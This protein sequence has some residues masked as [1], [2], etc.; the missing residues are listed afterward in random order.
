MIRAEYPNGEDF[1]QFNTEPDENDEYETWM[2]HVN[3]LLSNWSCIFGQGCPGLTSSNESRY[4]DDIGCCKM[5]AWF[6]DTEDYDRTVKMAAQLTDEDWDADKKKEAEKNGWA[7]IYKRDDETGHLNGKT[8][9][10]D[11]GCIFSN[12]STGSVGSTGKVGCAFH[13]LAERTNQQHVDV[14]PQVC[15]QLPLRYEYNEGLAAHVITPWD[16]DGWGDTDEDGSHDSI[17]C[18]WCVD[19]PEAYVGDKAVF[20]SMEG[21]LRRLMTD[22]VYEQMAVMLVERAKQNV[23]PVMPGSVRNDGRPM[24]PL[25]IGNRQPYRQPS[26]TNTPNI[27]ENMRNDH[28][29]SEATTFTEPA[30]TSAG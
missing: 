24:L 14:M 19:S 4:H 9:V 1:L 20:R 7:V 8:R 29:N 2:V 5:G 15:W 30:D 21:E 17:M 13:H 28:G 16:V 11:Q 27:I 18:W 22:A 10:V 26:A 3:F 6:S 25:L 12:R 23:P